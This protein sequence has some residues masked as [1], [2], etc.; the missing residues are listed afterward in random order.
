MSTIKIEI[1]SPKALKW[2]RSMQEHNLIR[3]HEE[4]DSKLKSYLKNSRKYASSA[5]GL[6]EINGIVAET[7]PQ[8]YAK[9]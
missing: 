5:P 2:I 9:R 3:I 6:A 4:S 1:L 7:R 8:R